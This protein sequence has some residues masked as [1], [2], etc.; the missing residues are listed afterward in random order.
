M[1]L[2][3]MK[4]A[5]RTLFNEERK[6]CDDVFAS[7]DSKE[8]CFADISRDGATILFTF[9]QHVVSK[10]NKN[11][12]LEKVFW[13]LLGTCHWKDEITTRA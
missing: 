2:E 11:S 7:S 8:S 13:L 6:L 9:P 10:I 1:W 3:V 5:V 12:P 4:V